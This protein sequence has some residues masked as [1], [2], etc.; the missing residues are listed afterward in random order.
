MHDQVPGLVWPDAVPDQLAHPLP[1][2]VLV[3]GAGG[4]IGGDVVGL[5]QLYGTHVTALSSTWRRP[6]PADVVITGDATDP[7]AVAAALDGVEAVVHMAAIPGEGLAEPYPGYRTNTG[8][9]FN[10][11]SRAGELGVHRCVLASSI[12]AFGVP[13]NHHQRLPAYYPIDEEIPRDLD[14]W[15]SLS[16][17]SDELSAEMAASHWGMTVIALRFPLT[18]LPSRVRELS[19]P[20]R[21]RQVREGWSY[22]DRRDAARAV[23]HALTAPLTG[24]HVIGLSAVDTFREEDTESLLDAYAPH[25]PRRRSFLGRAALIDTTRAEVRLGFRPRHTYDEPDP[26]LID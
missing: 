20:H 18:S 4:S 26:A 6:S 15:Y 7:D 23:L 11:L 12:N 19:R 16:K 14:D 9:T 8:A 17:A 21:H 25:V 22:L 10:V 3:T 1:G 24:A 5:L 2:R 13:A